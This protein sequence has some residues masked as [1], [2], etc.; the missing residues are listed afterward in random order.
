[1]KEL[2]YY[3]GGN[4]AKGFVHFFE[5]NF[6]GLERLFILKGGPGTG[7]SSIIKMIGHMWKEKGYDVERIHCS[8]DVNSLD[9]VIIPQ[10][11][12][13]IVDG[14]H[15][16]IIEPKYPG[17]VDEY[18][19]LGIAWNRQLLLQHKEEIIT[20][21]KKVSEGFQNAY[22]SFHAGLKN[23]DELEKIYIENIDF[24]RANQLAN[25][26]VKKLF[27]KSP[28]N[29]VGQVKHRFLGASTPDG[30]VNFIENITEDVENRYLIKGRAGSGKSTLLKKIA[31][32]AEERGYNV[33]VY[34]CGFDPD[35]LDMVIVRECNF[36]I[37]D[38]TPPHEYF[39]VKDKDMILDLYAETIAQG[40]DEKYAES[41]HYWTKK[42]KEKMD[43]GIRHLADT[44]KLRD[45]LEYVYVKAMDFDK[46]DKIRNQIHNELITIEKEYRKSV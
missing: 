34:H 40:T 1:V 29:G 2:N 37:F 8:S 11:K 7:K 17:V 27:P 43:E 19:N 23:H 25:D 20:L 18:I 13:G 33:E 14:T 30:P 31:K 38:S 24:D 3:A 12:V 28:Q 32:A 35:S 39:P 44:K 15:P 21:T 5:S 45:Q 26:W 22:R 36:A 46:V 41:I 10:L 42:Y 4:T 6:H 9:A 16:H